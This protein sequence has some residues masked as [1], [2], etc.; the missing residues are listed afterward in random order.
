MQF[1]FHENMMGNFLGFG[2][3][4]IIFFW[5]FFIFFKKEINL[6]ILNEFSKNKFRKVSEKTEYFNTRSISYI[7]N[8]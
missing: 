1:F 2:C 3:M 5:F 8:I 6:K 7:V 4:Y